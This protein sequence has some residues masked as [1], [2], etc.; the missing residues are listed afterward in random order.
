VFELLAA[1]LKSSVVALGLVLAIVASACSSSTADTQSGPS[2]TVET[3]E[4][5]PESAAAVDPGIVEDR[6]AAYVEFSSLLGSFGGATLPRAD[7]ELVAEVDCGRIASVSSAANFAEGWNQFNARRIAEGIN[8]DVLRTLT[9]VV[10]DSYCP[11]W[12][13]PVTAAFSPELLLANATAEA[14]GEEIRLAVAEG[15]L[16]ER[17]GTLVVDAFLG[18]DTYTDEQKAQFSEAVGER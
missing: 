15:T 12:N 1:S 6:D 4:P 17:G 11:Q 14:F 9:V 7:A 5:G 8:G 13:L 16:P 18:T 2:S 10:V 3:L